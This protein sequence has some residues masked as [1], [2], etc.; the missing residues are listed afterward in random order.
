MGPA[1]SEPSH[2]S[3]VFRLST[4]FLSCVV[5]RFAICREA[6][7]A[8]L[9]QECKSLRGCWGRISFFIQTHV[10]RCPVILVEPSTKQS[11]G[12]C[13]TYSIKQ[14]SINCS[15]LKHLNPMA[16]EAKPRVDRCVAIAPSCWKGHEI[17]GLLG[18]GRG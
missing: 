3:Q 16:G 5:I 9:G 12:L 13:V 10:A 6:S 15:N 2:C 17:A 18:S 11:R 8:H 4:I 1:K 7:V 14:K